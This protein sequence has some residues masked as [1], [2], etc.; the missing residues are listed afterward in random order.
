MDAP[1][2]P[3]DALD[4]L[5]IGRRYFNVDVEWVPKGD[6]RCCGRQFGFWCVQAGPPGWRSRVRPEPWSPFPVCP[7]EQQPPC[8]CE[9][10]EPTETIRKA[11]SQARRSWP[12]CCAT[13]RYV[14]Q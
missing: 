6:H 12:E 4:L 9:W 1:T 13:R 2:L 11:L 14:S 10:V 5:A 7:G 8:S 3:Q